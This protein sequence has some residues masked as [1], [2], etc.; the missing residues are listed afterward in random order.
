MR[1][2]NVSA[3]LFGLL[4]ILLTAGAVLLGFRGQQIPVLLLKPSE[5]AA[6]LTV[7]FMDAV[8]A[9]DFEDASSLMLG[10]PRLDTSA[11][12]ET[13]LSRLLWDGFSGSI[14]YEFRSGLYASD[15]GCC[16]DVAVTALDVSAVMDRLEQSA[17]S[18]LALEAAVSDQDAVFE[19]DG[20]YREEFVMNVLY[21]T[22]SELLTQGDVSA[23]RE[24]TLELV[25]HEGRWWIL[26]RQKLLDLFCG[27]LGQ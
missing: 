15:S 23:T 16:R 19:E 10:Q 7:D 21:G 2:P 13:E 26:P 12:A 9:G 11:E 5:E 18:L 27:N 17:Q 25:W 1:K 14:F 22:V 8:S 4:G 6:Q 3:L 20:S 24:I